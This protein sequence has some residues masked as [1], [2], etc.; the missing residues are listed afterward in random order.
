MN[1]KEL[2]AAVIGLFGQRAT[3]AA[4]DGLT[5]GALFGLSVAYPAA[6]SV[7]A[8]A[9]GLS[10]SVRPGR[11]VEAADEIVRTE[12]IREN[13]EYFLVGFGATAVPIL[14]AGVVL[15]TIGTSPW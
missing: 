14:A 1:P 12:Q 5:V 3:H 7:V 2:R 4:Q 10:G 11:I 13:P 8:A 15:G 9:L 6:L